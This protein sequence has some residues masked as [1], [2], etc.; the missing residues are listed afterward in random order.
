[1][2]SAKA[3][4]LEELLSSP[5]E[6]HWGY[7]LMRR[8]KISSGTLYPMLAQLEACGWL[9]AKWEFDRSNRGGPPRRAYRLTGE[10]MSQAPSAVGSFR[11]RKRLTD[12]SP[13]LPEPGTA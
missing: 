2:S 1:M 8:T 6:A 10:G 13:S 3:A 7:E 4:V 11:D 5:S 12:G 9:K